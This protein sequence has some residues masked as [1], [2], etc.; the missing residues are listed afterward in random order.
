MLDFFLRLNE[1]LE[2]LDNLAELTTT[3]IDVGHFEC[4]T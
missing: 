3:Y 1:I 4:E 2:K